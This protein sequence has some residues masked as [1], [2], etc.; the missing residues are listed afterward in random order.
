MPVVT[1][2]LLAAIA[3]TQAMPARG[4]DS[5]RA[6]GRQDSSG[7]YRLPPKD[8][9]LQASLEDV[10][11]EPPFA[12]LV[13]ERRLSV[14]LLDLSDPDSPVYAGIDD[15]SM[16]YAASLPKIAILLG[17]FD[18]VERGRMRYDAR[19]REELER[20]IRR[21]DNAAS[22][23][24]IERVGFETIAGVLE[25]PRYQLY[26]P[27]RRG[28]LW[29]GRDYGGGPGLWKR[30]PLHGISHGATTRQVTRF[31]AMMERGELV[32][33]WASAEMKR[34]MGDPAI[35][36]KFVRGLKD[37]PAHIYRKSG[38]WKR[39]HADAAIVERADHT[40]VAVALL[41]SGAA[42]GVLSSLILRLDEL[43]TAA[44]PRPG[45]DVTPS[46]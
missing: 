26:D 18:Q 1:L 2:T 35:E 4:P 7:G 12:T 32:S 15:D 5:T 39:W 25:D 10:L 33:P 23:D 19:L 6:A 43:I 41:E 44:G 27:S 16:R 34:I 8:P 11:A 9:H 17:V 13:A 40:Y 31:L 14:S 38:T 21:S 3:A 46:G 29:V 22:T 24:L 37:L 30:D 28:G 42:R 20:M 36:H 45:R